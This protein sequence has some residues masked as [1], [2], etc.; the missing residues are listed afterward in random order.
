MA[1][2]YAGILGPLAF[3][4]SLARGIAHGS[5]VETVVWTAWCHLLLFSAIGYLLGWLARRTVDESV[6]GRLAAELAA[7]PRAGPDAG[8]K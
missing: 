5:P 1:P 2:R 8:G 3:L 7:E 6:H 4:V